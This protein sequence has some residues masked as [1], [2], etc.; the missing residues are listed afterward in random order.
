MFGQTFEGFPLSSRPLC[1]PSSI[2]GNGRGDPTSDVRRLQDK[3]N[4]RFLGDQSPKG[5]VFPSGLR[6]SV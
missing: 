4:H 5:L 6:M 3:L 1:R 2:E